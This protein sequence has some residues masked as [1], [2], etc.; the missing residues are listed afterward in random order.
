VEDILKKLKLNFSFVSD[1]EGMVGIDKHAKE[2][3]S[4]L[5]VESAGVRIVGIWGMGG[6]GKTTIASAIYYKLATQFSSSSIILNVQQE[7]ERFGLQNIQN[8]YLSELLEENNMS[9]RLSLSNVRRL[10]RT[11]ALLVLDDVNNSAQLKDLIGMRWNYAPGSRIIVTSR[12]MQV[13]K[14]VDADAIYEVKEMNFHES[15]RLFCLNAFKQNYP[16]EDY[17]D[18]SEK[19]L[20]YAKG[21]PLALKVLGFL[22]CGRTKEAW[23]SQLQKLDKLPENDIFKVLKLSYEGL[24]EEQKDIFLDIACFYRGH[25]ENVVAQTLDICG[26]SAHIGMEV[27]KDRALISIS[28]GRIVMHDLIQEMGHEIIRQQCAWS[29]R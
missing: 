15:L 4:L 25:L 18:L 1:Y 3:E 13:L 22:L 10:K 29:A 2:I 12:D 24:D 23:E 5:N 9:S 28:E 19:I 16:V 14:N 20:N 21:V 11:K 6:I 8:K 27:L 7:I 17:V 26:F